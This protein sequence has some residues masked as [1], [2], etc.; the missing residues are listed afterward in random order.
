[1]NSC[2]CFRVSVGLMEASLSC[3]LLT[4]SSSLE[5]RPDPGRV[6]VLPITFH[7]L[8]IDLIMLLGIDKAFDSWLL[9]VHNYILE[10]FW[11]Y[12]HA[13]R[14]K[15]NSLCA[16]EKLIS[17]TWLSLQVIFRRGV[18][19]FLSNSVIIVV[20]FPDGL[21]LCLSLG[22]YKLHWV[23]RYSWIKQKLLVYI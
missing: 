6:C 3:F 17:Y 1:M 15:M 5:R 7:F 8:K 14:I 12:F 10:I 19:L 21:V 13:E 20:V 11:Q 23:D 22:C 16:I 4:L 9:P 2:D 18:I